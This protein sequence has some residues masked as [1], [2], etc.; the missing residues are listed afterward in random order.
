[1]EQSH[2]RSV[3]VPS[4]SDT[5][6]WS[7][8]ELMNHLLKSFGSVSSFLDKTDLPSSK[9]KLQEIISDPPKN[10][11]LHMELAITVDAMEPFV[12]ATYNLEGDGPLIFMAYEEIALLSAGI[13]NQHYPNTKAVAKSLTTTCIQQQQ[14]LDHAKSCVAPSYKYFQDK[15]EGDLKAIGLQ[16]CSYFFY[17]SRNGELKP[18]STDIDELKVFPFLNSSETLEEWKSELPSYISKSDGV[19][20]EFDKLVWWSSH[21][22]ELPNCLK[23]VKLLFLF[24]HHQQQLNVFF[25]C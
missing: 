13:L 23:H 1:M 21:Q 4:Y 15:F 24:S 22:N 20:T 9:L 25:L 5:H 6:W 16:I 8:W 18:S 17:P 12:K 2:W 10:R 19:S 14:L 11:K 3:P 7:K